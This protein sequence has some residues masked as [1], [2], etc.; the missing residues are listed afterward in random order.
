[1]V[2]T[3]V[4]LAVAGLVILG[5]FVAGMTTPAGGQGTDAGNE[6]GT[7]SVSGTGE[8][9]AEPD[10]AVVFVAA[11]AT[12]DTSSEAA[13]ELAG[14]VS[15]L[16]EA[17]TASNRTDD[18]RTTDY[19]IFQREEN[20]ART[21]VA[22]QA[23]E[24]GVPDTGDVGAVIDTAVGAGATEVNGVSFTL[25]EERRREI[26]A[27]AIDRAVGDARDRADAVAASTGLAVGEVRSVSVAD[28]GFVPLQ[29]EAA[30]AGTTIDPGPVTVTST[31][32][33]TYEASD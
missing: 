19:R 7:I 31:V 30:D 1:M 11:T 24:V 5:L 27:T 12:A 4:A 13:E 15:R 28:G 26:R 25:S 33:I 8:A 20:G 16:R 21:Y 22:R 18:V 6:I 14:N 3:P 9:S 23:F 32:R 17:L 10:R 29:R 2:R